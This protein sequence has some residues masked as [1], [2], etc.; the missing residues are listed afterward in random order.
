M[1]KHIKYRLIKQFAAVDNE[2]EDL[3]G[4]VTF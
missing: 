1:L 2:D 4:G 3:L